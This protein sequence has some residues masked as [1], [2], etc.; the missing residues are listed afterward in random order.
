MIDC[1]RTENYFAEKQRMTKKHKL[2][3]GK[4]TYDYLGDLEVLE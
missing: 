2:N 1:S 4:R 3:Q